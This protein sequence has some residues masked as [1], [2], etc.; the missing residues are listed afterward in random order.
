MT[1]KIPD[2]DYIRE[3][4]RL[5]MPPYHFDEPD[6]TMVIALLRQADKGIDSM[7]ETLIEID[8][9]LKKGGEDERCTEFINRLEDIG[10]DIR[11]IIRELRS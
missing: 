9:R 7:V 4:E 11:H 6:N 2:A 5:G 10:C 8:E 1:E 3:A